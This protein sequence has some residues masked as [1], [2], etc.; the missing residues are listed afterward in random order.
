MKEI[1]D[2]IKNTNEEKN[3]RL[4]GLT[5]RVGFNTPSIIRFPFEEMTLNFKGAYL[6]RVNE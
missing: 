2:I 6:I 1:E 5:L 4:I 3:Q